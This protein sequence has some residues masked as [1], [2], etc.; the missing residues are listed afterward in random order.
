MSGYHLLK[1][2]SSTQPVIA[3]SSGEAELYALVRGATQMTGMISLYK[4]V[5]IVIGGTVYTDS[6]AA[7]GISHRRG[8]GKTRHIQVQYLWIQEKVNNKELIVNKVGTNENVADLL[9]KHL[10]LETI[11]KHVH[12][13]GGGSSSEGLRKG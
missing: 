12:A 13:M 2:W 3:L 11:L 9:A 8:L 7:I 10:K 6:T 1:S 5:D 4:D